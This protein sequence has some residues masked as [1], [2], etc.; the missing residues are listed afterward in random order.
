MASIMPKMRFIQMAAVVDVPRISMAV[1]LACSKKS[2]GE[3][4]TSFHIRRGKIKNH[5]KV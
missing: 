2:S 3:G 4:S 5:R 1:L